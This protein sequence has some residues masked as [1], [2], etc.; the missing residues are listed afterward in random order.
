[1]SARGVC[2]FAWVYGPDFRDQL[3]MHQAMQVASQPV[4]AV[5]DDV[6]TAYLWLQQRH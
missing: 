4:I 6:A 2:A 5:F 1:M 3:A